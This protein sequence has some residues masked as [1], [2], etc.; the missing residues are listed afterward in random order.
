MVVG[1]ERDCA[2]RV[3]SMP[4]QLLSA[5]WFY[6]SLCTPSRLGWFNFIIL[7]RKRRQ[8]YLGTLISGLRI[9]LPCKIVH[10]S[11]KQTICGQDSLFDY[12]ESL[13]ITVT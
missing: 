2:L 7:L 8:K 4:Q 5:L 12:K 1:T 10:I 13:E 3:A 6:V 9:L 11:R